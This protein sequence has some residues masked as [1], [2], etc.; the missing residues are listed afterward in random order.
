MLQRVWAVGSK[1]LYF[2]FKQFP[3]HCLPAFQTPEKMHLLPLLLLLAGARVEGGQDADR[4][5]ELQVAQQR[6]EN[7]QE[8]NNL[9][10]KR[11]QN[12][13]KMKDTNCSQ[14]L[15]SFS[16]SSSNFTRCPGLLRSSL[17]YI[18]VCKQVCTAHLHVSQLP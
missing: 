5:E 17:I 12:Q 14:L 6:R 7:Q 11:L 1:A 9:Q 2:F 8:K 10:K 3:T 13:D 15:N 18:Q 4:L 16:E